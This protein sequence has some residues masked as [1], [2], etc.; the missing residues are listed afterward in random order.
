MKICMCDENNN[1]VILMNDLLPAL[2]TLKS[3]D[4]INKG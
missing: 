2:T 3:T 4:G 1:T